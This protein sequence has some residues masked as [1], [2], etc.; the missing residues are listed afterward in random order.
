MEKIIAFKTSVFVYNIPSK[1]KRFRM[2]YSR[3]SVTSVSFDIIENVPS[4]R[5]LNDPNYGGNNSNFILVTRQ[6][7]GNLSSLRF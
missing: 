5:C 1:N 4:Y 2:P 3:H 7:L 6:L